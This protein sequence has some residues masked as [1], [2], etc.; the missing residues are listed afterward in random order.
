MSAKYSAKLLRNGRPTR[1]AAMQTHGETVRL[2][3]LNAKDTPEV[4]EAIEIEP[5][6]VGVVKELLKRHKV[7]LV[8]GVVPAAQSVCRCVELPVSGGEMSDTIALLVETQLPGDAPAHRRAG[9][10]VRSALRGK[11]VA[12]LTAWHESDD[13]PLRA[14]DGVHPGCWMTQVAAM[15]ALRSERAG[16]I[17]YADRSAGTIALFATGDKGTVARILLEG[18]TE[19]NEW[20]QAVVEAI[21]ETSKAA[22][23]DADESN[24]Q[25][26]ERCLLM[27]P[28]DA[29]AL[30]ADVR[31]ISLDSAWLETFGI[32]LGAA[33]VAGSADADR[34]SLAAMTFAST[35][36]GE[37]ALTRAAHWISR[38]CNAWCSGVAAALLLL[39]TPLAVAWGTTAILE[40]KVEAAR[41]QET[42]SRETARQHAVYQEV[43]R[44]YFPVTK[45]LAD[46]SRATPIGIEIDSIDLGSI[47]D[48]IHI[49]GRA[50][51]SAQVI[52]FL[53]TMNESGIFERAQSDRTQSTDDGQ[54]EFSL[55]AFVWNPHAPFEGGTDF[56]EQSVAERMYN[57]VG[58]SNLNWK[59]NASGSQRV[60]PSRSDSGGSDG[61]SRGGRAR[62]VRSSLSAKPATGTVPE[63]ITDEELATT[64]RVSL[65]RA[66]IARK[67]GLKATEDEAVKDRLNEEIRKIDDRLNELAAG[68][69]S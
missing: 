67:S 64:N 48:E 35:E 29:S 56:A 38:P 62:P 36:G 12:L 4:L 26:A 50:E 7:E 51:N 57:V 21:N 11:S 34:R 15:Q 60:R 17:A 39:L 40:A 33:L 3:V 43:S 23:S 37:P 9:G 44:T 68:G 49:D 13:P 22:D 30:R 31:G 65:M 2:V 18:N 69:A 27:T 6:Q 47:S 46:I 45:I 59:S 25:I 41:E 55:T 20:T 58:A 54:V 16:L 1:V 66:K 52:E 28:A 8:V 53:S 19:T 42:R 32:A 63:P 10:M 14:P 5:G 24:G 61:S